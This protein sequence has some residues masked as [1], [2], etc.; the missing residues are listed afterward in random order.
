MKILFFGD[1]VGRVGRTGVKKI[2]PELKKQYQ[3]DIVIANGENLAHGVGI[4]PK[5]AHE[6]AETGIDLFTSGN[7]I[8]DKPNGEELLQTPDPIVIRP[9]NYGQRKSG[10]GYK[11]MDIDGQKLLIINLQGEVFIEDELDN[12]F[13]A[14]DQFLLAH[15]P[16]NYDAIFIDFHAEATSEKVAMGWH[17]DG[18]ASAV[19]GTHTHVPTADARILSKGTAYIT[20]AGMCGL[21]DGVIGVER[22]GILERFKQTGEF[23]DEKG[24]GYFAY[25]D[26]GMC[27]INAVLIETGP[28]RR[29]KSIDLIQRTFLA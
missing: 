10:V 19:V 15:A 9:L 21:R 17:A 23:L 16:K 28:K 13:I 7:H 25:S 14:L 26:E 12:P 11:E 5:T 2:L 27:D 1:I 6:M 24:G 3:P 8:W 20:D 29:A 18:R 4:T 22:E